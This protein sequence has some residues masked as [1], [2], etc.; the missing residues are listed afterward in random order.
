MIAAS[1]A[2]LTVFAVVVLARLLIPLLVFRFPLPAIVAALVIDAADQTIF[3]QLT[4]LDLTSYQGYDKALDIYYLAIAYIS[5][6]RNWHHP[7]A[8]TVATF[9]WYYRLVGVMLF[10]LT[11][12]RPLL[13]IFPNT[14]EYFFIFFEIVRLKWNTSRLDTRRVVGAAAAIWVF[15]KLPQEWWIHIAQLDFTDFMKEDLLGVDGTDSWSTAF[16]NRPGVTALIAAIVIGATAFVVWW[17]RRLPPGD[18]P[19][20]FDADKVWPPDHTQ[21][22]PARW[23]DGL[24]EKVVLLLLV[25]VIF[26]EGIPALTASIPQI[27]GA[28][29]VVVTANA[30]ISQALHQTRFGRAWQTPALAFVATLIVNAGIWAVVQ[31]IVPTDDEGA[32][33]WGTAF[34]LLLTSLIIALFDR[35]HPRRRPAGLHREF[36]PSQR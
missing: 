10:E 24:V 27:I 28:V 2:D 15:V 6:F 1:N 36:A 7:A 19:F 23:T 30:A 25:L 35:Y 14:F 34:F 26:S 20:T 32:S 4:D 12:W 18:H 11:E 8:L 33:R 9:L 21:P 16:A 17:W 29:I 22:A 5:T 3:Q 13:L 31:A